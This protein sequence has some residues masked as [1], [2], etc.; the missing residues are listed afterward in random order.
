MKHFRQFACVFFPAMF[1]L[2]HF[3]SAQSDE[4]KTPQPAVNIFFDRSRIEIG[5]TVYIVLQLS[6]NSAFQLSNL[7]LEMDAPRFLRL[8]SSNGERNTHLNPDSVRNHSIL[9]TSQLAIVASSPGSVGDFNIVLTLSYEWQ[10]NNLKQQGQVLVEKSL[11][12]GFFGTDNVVGIPL[13]FAQFIVPG[14]FFLLVLR[15]LKVMGSKDLETNEKLI[16][17]VLVSVFCVFVVNAIGRKLVRD[18]DLGNTISVGKLFFLALT[19][20]ILG[21]I[22]AAGWHWWKSKQEKEK[23]KLAFSGSEKDAELIN[24]ALQLNP[25]YE[26]FAWEFMCKDGSVYHGSH[27]FETPFSYILLA[28]FLIEAEDLTD[29]DKEAIK[30]HFNGANI[31]QNKKDIMAVL[32]IAGKSAT[33]KVSVRDTVKRVVKGKPLSVGRSFT[34]NKDEYRSK[35]NISEAYMKL[36]VLG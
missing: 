22:T 26:G 21:I 1:F 14:L 15:L 32:E 8:I 16:A 7:Q 23:R 6:N 10:Q 36:L 31:A 11:K 30:K 28:A 4:I 2:L 13:A 18:F 20:T 27:Y 19:G 3:A 33:A 5:D 12:I 34:I 24:K 17:G 29:A 35:T 25:A 9:K